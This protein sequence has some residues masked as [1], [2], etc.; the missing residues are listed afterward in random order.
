MTSPVLFLAALIAQ[1][2]A[3]ATVPAGDWFMNLVTKKPELFIS[4]LMVV[5]IVAVTSICGAFVRIAKLN[6]AHRER[7]AMI[8]RGM[9]PDAASADPDD[10]GKSCGLFRK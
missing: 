9:S 8:E 4:C 7:L 5:C 10:T 1:A 3:E 2:Q 6:N